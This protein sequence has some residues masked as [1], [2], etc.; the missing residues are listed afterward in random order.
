M[1]AQ[2]ATRVFSE[3]SEIHSSCST[4]VYC[5]FSFSSSAAAGASSSFGALAGKHPQKASL[6]PLAI[7]PCSGSFLM[8][9][10]SSKKEA[11]NPTIR[12]TNNK[13]MAPAKMRC[14]ISKSFAEF[15]LGTHLFEEYPGQESLR[16]ILRPRLHLGNLSRATTWSSGTAARRSRFWPKFS[17]IGPQFWQSLDHAC[18]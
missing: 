13:R 6:T 14:V 5:P 18:E 4:L 10:H 17:W 7:G 11:A 3:H 1:C 2:H 9:S 15:F 16:W 12:K 8:A